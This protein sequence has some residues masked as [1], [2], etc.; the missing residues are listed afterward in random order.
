MGGGVQPPPQGAGGIPPQQGMGGSNPFPFPT[1]T[2]GNVGP[3]PGGAPPFGS[4]GDTGF[5]GAGGGIAPPPPPT[6]GTTGTGTCC[7]SGDCLCHGP[8]PTGLTSAKGP[9]NTTSFAA[10]TVGTIHYPTDAEGLLAGVAIC[11]GFLNSGPEM[12]PWGPFYASWGIV[13]VV[14]NTI[15][16]DIPDIRAT[17]LL[18]AVEAMK[19][20]NTKS[21]SPLNGKMAGRYGTSGYSMGGGG[22]T[23]AAGKTPAL[24][25]SIGLAPWGGVG[26]GTTVPTLL[27]CGSAD[28]VAPCNMSQTVYT[29]LPAQTPKMMVTISGATHFNWFGPA[30]AGRG[31]SGEIALAFQKVYLEGDE[32]WKPL[33]QQAEGQVTTNIQ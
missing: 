33:I 24:K 8:N 10:G 7:S 22:T 15:A 14:T 1:G 17:K 11:P 12:A 25:S 30:D 21:G 32:R 5:A 16:T 20:E 3:G 29:Q 23:I 9:Y 18:A 4:G 19:A 6:G 26:T 2:G 28:T 27:L 13:T 31:A